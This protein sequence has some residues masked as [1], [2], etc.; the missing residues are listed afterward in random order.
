MKL[1]MEEQSPVIHHL[2]KSS[3]FDDAKPCRAGSP[4]LDSKWDIWLNGQ[5]WT[6]LHLTNKV[7]N[8]ETNEQMHSIYI[9]IEQDSNPECPHERPTPNPLR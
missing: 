5:S 3:T 1:C 2:L 7:P 8:K 4:F 9:G 6:S